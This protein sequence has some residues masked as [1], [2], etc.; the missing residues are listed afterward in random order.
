M[1]KILLATGLFVGA[2][3]SVIAQFSQGA[4]DSAQIEIRQ[5]TNVWNE[6]IIHPDSVKLDKMR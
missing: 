4:K 1:K 5:L 2:L 3:F 6:A